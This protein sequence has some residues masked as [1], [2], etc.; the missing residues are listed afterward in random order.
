LIQIEKNHVKKIWLQKSLVPP[1][2]TLVHHSISVR[3]SGTLTGKPVMVGR[4]SK[5]GIFFAQLL[6]Y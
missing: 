3:K 1:P 6:A 2:C 5:L 4:Q